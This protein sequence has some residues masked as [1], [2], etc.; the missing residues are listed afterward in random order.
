[1][2]AGYFSDKEHSI[3]N[4]YFEEVSK[5]AKCISIEIQ[6]GTCVE[7]DMRLRGSMT[8]TLNEPA[9]LCAGQRV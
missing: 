1:M 6:T 8:E 2:E 9:E 3:S 7:P 4:G 5:S